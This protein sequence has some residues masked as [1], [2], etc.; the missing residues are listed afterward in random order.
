ME[1]AW[2]PEPLGAARPTH[3]HR[4][5]LA[6]AMSEDQIDGQARRA[7]V[8]VTS[9]AISERALAELDADIP[10]ADPHGCRRGTLKIIEIERRTRI[11]KPVRLESGDPIAPLERRASI[12]EEV[13][14]A[15]SRLIHAL[16]LTLTGQTSKGT[17]ASSDHAGVPFWR[18]GPRDLS[19]LPCAPSSTRWVWLRL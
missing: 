12:S 16:I 14:T 5:V 2:R 15:R 6:Y 1:E 8:F 17:R 11:G 3:C 9:D 4:E 13:V 19:R 18:A 10:L 7:A